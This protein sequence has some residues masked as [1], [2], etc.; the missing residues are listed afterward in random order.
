M[1]YNLK[2]QTIG[3]GRCLAPSSG[4]AVPNRGILTPRS[5]TTEVILLSQIRIYDPLRTD[6][7][8][9]PH[10]AQGIL[11]RSPSPIAEAGVVEYRFEDR[12]QPVQQRLLTDAVVDLRHAEHAILARS[13]SLRD[14]VLAHWQWLVGILFQLAMQPVQLRTQLRSEG[15]QGL[16]IYTSTAPVLLHLLPCHLQILPLVHLVD[17]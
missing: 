13:I 16:T 3:L 4:R 9:L 2:Y 11:R 6:L 17:S 12:F 15:L 14:R 10:F 1:V 7:D 5:K 8:F